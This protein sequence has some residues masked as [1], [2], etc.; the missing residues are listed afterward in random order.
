ML[1]VLVACSATGLLNGAR[2]F[3]P[4]AQY[5]AR[6]ALTESCTGL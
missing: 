3:T 2:R 4:P 1:V 6:S 5:R